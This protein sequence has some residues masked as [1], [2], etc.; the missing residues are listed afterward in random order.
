QFGIY[1]ERIDAAGRLVG[2]PSKLVAGEPATG[3]PSRAIIAGLGVA[4]ALM[5][6]LIGIVAYPRLRGAPT[7]SISV[8][9]DPTAAQILVNDVAKGSAPLLISDLSADQ[10]FVVTARL[11]GYEDALQPV[12]VGRD[13]TARIALTLHSSEATITVR[14][15]PDGA[16]ILVGGKEIG[17]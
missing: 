14:T 6:V 16:S 4:I 13:A 2:G 1:Q 3:R 17:A 9:T 7:G 12:V 5:L 15:D 11:P 10:S 8:T